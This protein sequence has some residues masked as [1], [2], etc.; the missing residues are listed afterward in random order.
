MYIPV[1][2]TSTHG[3]HI[4]PSTD[5]SQSI[6]AGSKQLIQQPDIML[7]HYQQLLP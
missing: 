1:D 2:F 7:L 6:I 5:K 3:R 4:V